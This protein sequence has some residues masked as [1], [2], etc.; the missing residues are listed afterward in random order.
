[1]S[2]RKH[3]QIIGVVFDKDGTLLDFDASWAPVIRRSASLAACGDPVLADRL[4][5]AC[6]LDPVTGRTAA[7][8]LFAAANTVEIAH[9]MISAG[10]PMAAGDL[11]LAL[12]RLFVEGADH[13]VPVTDLAALFARLR[14]RSIRI[15]V[16]SSDN[17]AS[18][19]RSLSML[20]VAGLVDFVAGYD[21]GYGAK[22]EP[23]MV[24]AFCRSTGCPV[25]QT[26]IVGDN[27]HDLIMGRAAGAALVVGVLTGTG[28]RET[29]A[30]LADHVLESIDD[31]PAL[32]AR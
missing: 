30:T 24:A 3:N 1:M 7:D 27:R 21:S 4:L 6:G 16:A 25:D 18:I 19:R 31:L 32:L 14:S 2:R 13:A 29:L 22:P 12:D 15:G 23:G 28:T 5:L 26:A 17:E 8:S 20:G 10:S 9:G 11:V